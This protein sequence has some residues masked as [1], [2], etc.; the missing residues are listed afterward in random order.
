MG[1]RGVW[2]WVIGLGYFMEKCEVVWVGRMLMKNGV[3]GWN[4]EWE[5]G[6]GKWGDGNE[7]GRGDATRFGMDGAM[8]SFGRWGK[9]ADW[10]T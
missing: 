10:L 2:A 6:N 4:G 9:G 8:A 5:M 1:M 3:G 7:Y